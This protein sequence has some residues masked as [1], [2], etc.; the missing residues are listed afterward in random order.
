LEDIFLNKEFG[1]NVSGNEVNALI[2]PFRIFKEDL[3]KVCKESL[4]KYFLYNGSDV[5]VLV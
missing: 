5:A 1:R 3:Q 4:R 2:Y